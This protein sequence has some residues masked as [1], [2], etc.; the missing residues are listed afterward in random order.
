MRLRVRLPFSRLGRAL[1]LLRLLCLAWLLAS[2]LLHA[3]LAYLLRADVRLLPA[4]IQRARSV[5]LVVAHPDDESLFFGPAVLGV[6]AG[7]ATMGVLLLSSGVSVSASASAP[8]RWHEADDRSQATTTASAVSGK[9]RSRLVA[10]RCASTR[11]AVSSSTTARCRT[12]RPTGGP[13]RPSRPTCA[14]PS[15]SGPS[16]WCACLCP[17]CV[18][19]AKCRC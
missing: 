13:S 1:P 17:V 19:R 18:Q 3:V 10:V 9:R 8:P 7:G 15:I 2:V 11:S 6:G 5:L 14:T 12:A 4:T 16:T